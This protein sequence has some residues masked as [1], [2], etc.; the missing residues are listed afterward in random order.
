MI[1]SPVNGPFADNKNVAGKPFHLGVI[2]AGDDERSIAPLRFGVP[3]QQ[4]GFKLTHGVR[5]QRRRGFIQQQDFGLQQQRP[6]QCDG[7][8]LTS[9]LP[10]PVT[11]QATGAD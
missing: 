6:H 7:L 11:G 5:V 8:P 3:I 2:M 1:T 9:G 10:I 4:H